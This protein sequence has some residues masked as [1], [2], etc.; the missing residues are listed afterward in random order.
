MKKD[1]I[2]QSRHQV[3]TIPVAEEEVRIGKRT[4]TTGVT[5]VKKTIEE[6]EEIV[7]EPLLAEEIEIERV[8]INRFVEKAFPIRNEDDVTIVPV[9]EEV[10]VV[11]KRLR[12][13]EE[14][15][16]KKVGRQKHRP[17]KVILRSEKAVVE[18]VETADEK[19]KG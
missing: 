17:E 4:R 15:R 18:H 5:R 1:H 16:I 19:E 7:D 12:L 10:M 9:F 3:R 13:K 2:E 6:R 14:V 8:P 11:E